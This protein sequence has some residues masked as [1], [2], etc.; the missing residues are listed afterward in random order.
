M[1]I[2]FG[3]LTALGTSV[4]DILTRKASETI[5]RYVVIWA[6]WIFALPL[7]FIFSLTQ[8]PVAIE[9]GF[10]PVVVVTAI[11]LTVSV[12]H[13]V[14]AVE[15]GDL[16]L[17]IPILSFT[18]V[19]LLITAPIITGEIPSLD[20]ALGIFVIIVGAYCLFLHQEHTHWTAPFKRIF[21]NKGSRYM[22]VV[23]LMFSIAGSFDK[24][25][26]LK[27]SGVV[28]LL[29]LISALSILLT[30]IMFFKCKNICEEFRKNP[31]LLILIGCINAVTYTTQLLGIVLTQVPY[32]IA[33]KRLSVL[34]S[35]LYGVYIL[36]EGNFKE[37]LIGVLLMLI[38]VFI[39]SLA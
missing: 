27:A 12:I 6:W 32:L 7:L 17:S 19:L 1:W 30:I 14:K 36:K 5:N 31:R 24:V 29:H 18:P 28:Y 2:L 4:Q 35:T 25:G 20:G 38:G 3:I 15:S 9:D 8:K 11:C 10:Y 23:V 39:V 16:S 13:Y 37:R 22:C 34:F 26:T 33:V 21:K